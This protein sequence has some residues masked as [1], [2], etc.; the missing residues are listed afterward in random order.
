MITVAG[1]TGT[2]TDVNVT[3]HGLTHTFTHDVDVL[4]TDQ[5]AFARVIL[6]ADAGQTA[7]NVDLTFDDGA[8]NFLPLNTLVTGSYKPGS[9]QLP[10]SCPYPQPFPQPAPIG[11]YGTAL[12]VF[13]TTNPNGTWY[14]YVVD[15]CTDN[16]GSIAGGWTLDITT[17]TTAVTVSSL[18]AR[19]AT[20]GVLVR[21]RT[22]TEADLL[23]FH[24]YRSR[25]HSWRRLNRSLITAKGSVSGAAYRFLDRTARGG[26]AYRYRIKAVNRDGTMSWFGPVRVT[27]SF[28]GVL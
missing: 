4:V 7:G 3:L 16:V 27:Y 21:W 11:A 19:P 28:L 5:G 17:T 20:R 18:S 12:S 6:M 13:N 15:D 26:V 25:G 8:A 22:G 2:I 24:V 23:G 10:G 14:L 9:I 1:L